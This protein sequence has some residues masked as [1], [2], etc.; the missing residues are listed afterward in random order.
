MS[1]TNKFSALF[2]DDSDS[3]DEIVYKPTT[4]ITNKKISWVEMLEEE[5]QEEIVLKSQNNKPIYSG[6]EIIVLEPQK[7][8]QKTHISLIKN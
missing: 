1:Y 2:N 6:D 4:K 8:R 3:E 5:E 7:K